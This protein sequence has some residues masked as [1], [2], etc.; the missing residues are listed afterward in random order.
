[1]TGLS[2]IFS[3]PGGVAKAV[4]D[5]PESFLG[6]HLVGEDPIPPERLWKRLYNTVLHSKPTGLAVDLHQRCRRCA[7]GYFLIEQFRVG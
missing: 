4:L 5:G 6:R 2:E 1:M 7:V 3:V